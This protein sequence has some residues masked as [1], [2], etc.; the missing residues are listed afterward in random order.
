MEVVLQYLAPEHALAK[1]AMRSRPE[2]GGRRGD[3]KG[4]RAVLRDG[5]AEDAGGIPIGQALEQR[6]FAL[7]TLSGDEYS[8]AA[9]VNPWAMV[10]DSDGGRAQKQ[11]YNQ[12]M[13]AMLQRVTGASY[14]RST[15]MVLR[16]SSIEG[17]HTRERGND[18]PRGPVNDIHCDFTPTAYAIDKF[19]AY[20]KRIGLDECP[21]TVMNG[22]RNVVATEPVQQWAMAVCDTTSVDAG[23][24]LVSRIS[25]ENGNTIYAL[26]HNPR[27]RWFTYPRMTDKEVLLFKQ[28]DTSEAS[29]SRF[30]PHT[31]Y[32]IPG[33]P[34]SAPVRQ[35]CEIRALCFFAEG[36][37]GRYDRA[38][39][40]LHK[41]GSGTVDPALAAKLA[42]RASL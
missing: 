38:L 18:A 8:A 42:S 3:S 29:A 33:R 6:G 15:N 19:K 12:A 16:K 40:A 23:R 1:E 28:Y 7:A 14:V 9:S 37:D 25:P 32:D 41:S 11:Q 20:A 24:D 5:R 10:E 27:H 4:Y 22:W 39:L 21:F 30:T 35:S 26:L 31:A 36:T 2:P 13:E 34:A 17:V